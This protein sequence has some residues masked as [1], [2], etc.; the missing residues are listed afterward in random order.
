MRVHEALE[1][2][3]HLGLGE[4]PVA[5]AGQETRSQGFL[6]STDLTRKCPWPSSDVPTTAK[7]GAG[8]WREEQSLPP[9]ADSGSPTSCRHFPW[10]CLTPGKD[11][12]S[13]RS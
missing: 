3:C 8:A 13:L 7:G 10:Q 2:K 6:D 12:I 11:V 4:D 1:I 5:Q 9:S